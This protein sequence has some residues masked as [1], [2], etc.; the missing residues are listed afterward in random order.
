MFKFLSKW[1]QLYGGP[2]LEKNLWFI[3]KI[4][5]CFDDTYCNIYVRT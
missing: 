2:D 1:F 3:E 5:D 4:D